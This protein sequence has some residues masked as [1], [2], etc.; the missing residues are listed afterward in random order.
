[1]K[2]KNIVKLIVAI[3]LWIIFLRKNIKVR[4]YMKKYGIK[5][6]KELKNIAEAHKINNYVLDTYDK[7]CEKVNYGSNLKNL[8][9]K[10]KIFYIAMTT[11]QEVYNGGFSKFFINSSGDF[12][13]K[14]VEAFKELG[15]EELAKVCQDA[16]N[17]LK[18]KIPKNREKRLEILSQIEDEEL[19]KKLS[20]CDNKFYKYDSNKLERMEYEYLIKNKEYFN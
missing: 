8:N 18:V 13:N 9:E 17:V 15:I 3:I 12:S 19:M 5:S 2:L 7:I 10:E 1:M 16:I 11:Q 6:Y 4:K 20:E 14:I